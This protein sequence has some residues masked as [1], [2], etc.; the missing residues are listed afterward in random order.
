[1]QEVFMGSGLPM[2]AQLGESRWD[3]TEADPASLQCCSSLIWVR[4]AFKFLRDEHV[5]ARLVG[6]YSPG[7]AIEPGKDKVLCRWPVQSYS[8]VR[9]MRELWGTLQLFPQGIAVKMI[10]RSQYIIPWILHG[11]FLKHS[12]NFTSEIAANPFL[13]HSQYHQPTLA[14]KGIGFRSQTT[15]ESVHTTEKPK[16]MADKMLYTF[17]FICPEIG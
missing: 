2:D 15:S 10:R 6:V 13:F 3:P 4:D 17:A 1:M 9:P 7:N 11:M 5:K 16:R 8:R 12:S 14:R